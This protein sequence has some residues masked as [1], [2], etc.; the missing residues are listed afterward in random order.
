[1]TS[2]LKLR[3]HPMQAIIKQSNKIICI[4]TFTNNIKI[5][6]QIY[7]CCHPQKQ[8]V[9]NFR[10]QRYSFLI[11]TSSSIRKSSYSL[12][13]KST[14]SYSLKEI[15]P[16]DFQPHIKEPKA[17]FNFALKG[18][19]C[20]GPPKGRK[21][22]PSRIVSSQLSSRAI[23]FDCS[24]QGPIQPSFTKKALPISKTKVLNFIP[25]ALSCRITAVRKASPASQTRLLLRKISLEEGQISKNR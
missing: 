19:I 8:E 22:W 10:G 18:L 12:K 3:E 2:H 7:T 9:W 5:K 21:I 15:S 17:V 20:T 25:L 4:R 11:S 23:Q 16:S 14:T 1:M 13:L 24:Y 6:Y